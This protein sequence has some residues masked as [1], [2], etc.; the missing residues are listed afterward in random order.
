MAGL[1]PLTT[2]FTPASGCN[3]VI[4]GIVYTQ[5]LDDGNITTHKYHS[6]G[7]SATSECYPPAFEVHSYYSPGICP[8]GWQSAC[9]KQEAIGG[10]IT[11]TRVTCCPSGYRCIDAPNPTETWSTLS[12]SSTA[13]STVS[14]TVPDESN[15]YYKVTVLNS[16]LIHAAA[17]EVRWQRSDFI[18]SST[19]PPTSSFF[20]IST[21]FA[22]VS[23]SSA[24]VPEPTSNASPESTSLSTG[25]KVGIGLGGGCLVLAILAFGFWWRRKQ[26]K[27]KKAGLSA[28]AEDPQLGSQ[29]TAKA[30]AE[31]WEQYQQEL[32]TSSNTAEMVTESN[33]HEFSGDSRPAELP[34]EHWRY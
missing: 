6:L 28:N 27:A 30:P 9:G 32:Y 11:E 14:V 16:P 7:L 19:N 20:S 8:S 26:A 10:S 25:A 2:T 23:S 15:Q 18:A 17:V 34:V 3:S 29:E 21:T 33:R 13:I 24:I 31:M 4:S 1:G 12:C 5:T 22:A